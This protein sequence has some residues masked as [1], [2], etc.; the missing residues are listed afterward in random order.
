MRCIICG[1]ELPNDWV[2]YAEGFKN[3]S[4]PLM[5]K[6]HLKQTDEMIFNPNFVCCRGCNHNVVIPIRCMVMKEGYNKT[7]LMLKEWLKKN[8]LNLI[9]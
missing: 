3:N 6:K 2:N 4:Y 5:S 1:R 8:K 7:K 9:Q